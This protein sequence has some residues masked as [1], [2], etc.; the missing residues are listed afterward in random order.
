MD[1]PIDLDT[2]L[3]P[4][5]E[6]PIDSDSLDTGPHLTRPGYKH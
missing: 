6:L 4:T 3:R 5:L 1:E 2:W